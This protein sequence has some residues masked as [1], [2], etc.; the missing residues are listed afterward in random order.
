MIIP[1]T[2][3]VFQAVLIIITFSPHNHG[4]PV[5]DPVS[6]LNP[7][8]CINTESDSSWWDSSPLWGDSGS[9]SLQNENP[10]CYQT[11]LSDSQKQSEGNLME[12]S[13][14]ERKS[15]PVSPSVGPLW[16]RPC[17]GDVC[18]RDKSW[19][20]RLQAAAYHTHTLTCREY[21]HA[22]ADSYGKGV[23][24][25]FQVERFEA[26]GGLYLTSVSPFALQ[27]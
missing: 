16:P 7:N 8:L 5:S 15:L 25:D 10:D 17:R 12:S 4:S 26:G 13:R 24:E 27:P 11:P 22:H 18:Q 20:E 14:N 23:C 2:S 6:S 1:V 19:G 9:L 3:I 21:T